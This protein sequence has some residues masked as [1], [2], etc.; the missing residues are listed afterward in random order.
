MIDTYVCGETLDALCLVMAEVT[1][2]IGPVQGVEARAAITDADGNVMEA[3]EALGDPSKYYACIRSDAPV[4]LPDGVVT[5]DT[6]LGSRLVGVW[7]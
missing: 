5:I 4:T 3:R 7:A 6:T 2:M 1:N